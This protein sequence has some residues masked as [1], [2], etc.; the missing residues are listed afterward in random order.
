MSVLGASGA[1]VLSG[2]G[3][4]ANDPSKIPAIARLDQL[5]D[6]CESLQTIQEILTSQMS[7]L[8]WTLEEAVTPPAE[9]K[10]ITPRGGGKDS[11]FAP[12]E[13]ATC[14]WCCSSEPIP[15]PESDKKG[16][17]KRPT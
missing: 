1:K 9:Q 4:V 16:G 8:N 10:I 3:L 15:E 13:D 17:K 5:K 2:W 6:T 12:D 14:C 7:V 11:P